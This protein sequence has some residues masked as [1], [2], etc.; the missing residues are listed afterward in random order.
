MNETIA[1]IVVI[2]LSVLV[3]GLLV[4]AARDWRASFHEAIR[5][6]VQDGLRRSGV[7]PRN[8]QGDAD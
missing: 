6:G 1:V 8:S 2:V 7:T 3:C 4:F 5:R